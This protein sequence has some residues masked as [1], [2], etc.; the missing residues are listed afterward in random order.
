M[1]N[2]RR[3]IVTVRANGRAARGALVRVFAPGVTP[4]KAK[5]NRSGRVTFRVKKLSARQEAGA[6]EA[7][8]PRREDGLPV[9][10]PHHRHQVLAGAGPA[11]PLRAV[12]RPMKRLGS[13][14]P[15]MMTTGQFLMTLTLATA[16]LALWS[17]VR[18][19]GAV[20][21]TMK[22]AAVRVVIALVLLQVGAAA[23]GLGIAA[24]PSWR[25]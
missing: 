20:P 9:R 24:A 4:L 18:W 8:L 12:S 13:L 10:A 21:A 19:P 2:G 11:R 25:S 17:Y 7:A 15:T 23:F 14:E 3:V 22:G 6:P 1:A 5:T 16:A